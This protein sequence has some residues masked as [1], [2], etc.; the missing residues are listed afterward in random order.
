[1]GSVPAHSIGPSPLWPNVGITD[2]RWADFI[3]T[4]DTEELRRGLDK[5]AHALSLRESTTRCSTADQPLS[6][7]NRAT[8]DSTAS[9][10]YDFDRF[11]VPANSIHNEHPCYEESNIILP[12]VDPDFSLRSEPEYLNITAFHVDPDGYPVPRTHPTGVLNSLDTHHSESP[13]A[14]YL[15]VPSSTQPSPQSVKRPYFCTFCAEVGKWILFKSKGD[16]KLHEQKFHDDTGLQ[17]PCGAGCTE[18]FDR[19]RDLEE[20]NDKEHDTKRLPPGS[21]KVWVYGCGFEHCRVLTYTWDDRCNHVALC[22]QNATMFS[23]TYNRTI[24]TLLKAEKNS[25]SIWKPI[26]GGLDLKQMQWD[27]VKTRRMR[28]QLGN[29]DVMHNQKRFFRELF[30]AGIPAVPVNHHRHPLRNPSTNFVSPILHSGPTEDYPIEFSQY[31]SLPEVDHT[32]TQPFH[33]NVYYPHT[34]NLLPRQSYRNSVFM[35]D[36]PY[37]DASGGP[38]MLEDEIGAR[39]LIDPELPG[40]AQLTLDH[41]D[42]PANKTRTL[43]PS[44][45]VPS[46]R[47]RLLTKSKECLRSRLLRSVP[48]ECLGFPSLRK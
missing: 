45:A 32:R 27:P 40:P 13:V 4:L 19:G 8:Y 23:W 3:N 43:S 24:R 20:H 47:R 28:Q 14:A 37:L 48:T 33:N 26:L 36:G 29:Y 10:L 6:N 42:F 38:P 21:Q 7:P 31:V 22:M 39:P 35:T 9:T 2:E 15:H 12:G 16:W 41:S 25:S 34:V 46:R 5:F 18:V 17:W 44:A 1:M 30:K 11:I